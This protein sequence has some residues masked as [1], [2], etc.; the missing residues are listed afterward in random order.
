MAS[1]VVIGTLIGTCFALGWAIAGLQGLPSR[2]RAIVFALALLVS[3]SIGAAVLWRGRSAHALAPSGSFDG[4]IYGWEVILE[5]LAIVIAVVA[6]RKSA[7]SDYIMPTVAFIVGAHF[8]G[9]AQAMAFGSGRVFDWIGSIVCISAASIL[10][11]RALSFLSLPQT[12]ALTG[13]SCAIILWASALST[14]I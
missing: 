3:A 2:W 7:L 11:A 14:L 12:I 8:F 1:G 6:L 4:A 9:L 10:F 13:F 5:S